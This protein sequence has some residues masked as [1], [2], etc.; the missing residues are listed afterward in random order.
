MASESRDLTGGGHPVLPTRRRGMTLV[1]V[2]VVIGIIGV[3]MA[4]LFP[5]VQAVRGRVRQSQ[6]SNNLRQI[7]LAL[8][9]YTGQFGRFLFGVGVDSGSATYTSAANRRYS[10]H[11]MP[12]CASCNSTGGRRNRN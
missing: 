8:S 6:C 4:I 1:E 2:V 5:A 11:W 3:L 10:T 12:A 9:N 7:G